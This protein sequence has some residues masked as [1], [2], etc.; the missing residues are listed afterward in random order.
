MGGVVEASGAGFD[1]LEGDAAAA[2]VGDE[3]GDAHGG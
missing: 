2:G 3:V 1:M